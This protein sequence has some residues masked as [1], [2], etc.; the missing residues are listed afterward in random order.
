MCNGWLILLPQLI[1]YELVAVPYIVKA[2]NSERP[3]RQ[4]TGRNSEN[5]DDH[6]DPL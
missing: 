1:F 2:C 6:H 3:R 5:G 4:Y